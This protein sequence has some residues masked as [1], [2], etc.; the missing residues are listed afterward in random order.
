MNIE[1]L[2]DNGTDVAVVSSN[3]RLITDTQS[4]LDLAMTVK[5]ET[6][7]S[8]IVIVSKDTIVK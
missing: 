2:K 5:Y 4:A 7:A 3:E 1:H 6:G 8:N